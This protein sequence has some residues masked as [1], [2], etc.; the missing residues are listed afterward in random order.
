MKKF[1]SK[2]LIAILILGF[3]FAPVTPKID[4]QNHFSLVKNEARA[5]TKYYFEYRTAK[6]V[7]T[8]GTGALYTYTFHY[9]SGYD[10][11]PQCQAAYDKIS[12]DDPLKTGSK[13]CFPSETPPDNSTVTESG[14][15][16]KSISDGDFFK[17]NLIESPLQC[18]VSIL[19]Y[20][21]WTPIAWIARLS[22]NIL[23]FF[24]YYSLKSTSYSENTFVESGWAVVRD[25]ANIFFIV[26]LLYVAGKTV[27]GMNASDNKK[28][29][30]MVIIMAL[31]INF[32]LFISKV[33]IDASNILARVFYS[34]IENVNEN[35]QTNTTGD[36]GE[37]EITVGLVKVFDP[38]KLFQASNI[39]NINDHTGTFVILMIISGALMIYMII[40]FLSIAFLFVGRVVGLWI[41]MI[42]A[43]LAFASY[44]MPGFSIPKFNHRDWWSD[45]FKL[46]FMAPIFIFFL[47]LIVS[48]GDAFKIV[49]YGKDGTAFVDG[50]AA[51]GDVD[52]MKNYL[53]VIIPF[54]LIYVILKQAKETT[55]KMAGDIAQSVN[56]AGKL[57]TGAALG[58]GAA[59]TAM[60][61]RQTIGATAKYAVND[62]ARGKDKEIRARLRDQFNN[63][64]LLGKL[65]VFAYGKTIGKGLAAK[66]AEVITTKRNARLSDGS[67]AGDKYSNLATQQVVDNS[68]NNKT[69]RTAFGRMLAKSKNSAK[70]LSHA[71]H[72]L[73]HGADEVEKGA[74]YASLTEAQQDKVR[75]NV[76]RDELAKK[77]F[78]VKFADIKDDAEKVKL[79]DTVS[80][81]H[82][83]GEI[84]N[85]VHNYNGKNYSPEH[86]AKHM[87]GTLSNKQTETSAAVNE[88]VNALR[89]GSFDIRNLTD[90]KFNSGKGILGNGVFLAA[91]VAT[92]MRMGL[93]N[94]GDVNTGKPQKDFTKDLSNI[95]TGALKGMKIDIKSSGGGAGHDDGHGKKDDHGGGH[96]GGHH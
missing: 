59:G 45:L 91:A 6:H 71:K 32:S 95:I 19:Y 3:F 85:L 21:V 37:K 94:I 64:S 47:Y 13:T 61:A 88:F 20:L 39:N 1:F 25:I 70:D 44:T 52:T 79:K 53:S 69:G 31:L 11:L 40:T 76:N 60:I 73:D 2:I 46:S 89:K 50:T 58:L 36:E 17:C 24:I 4:T 26:A 34:S 43:P 29:I 42:F 12:L 16:L 22:A 74:T 63:S 41:L 54:A 65:N 30:S 83:N 84:G 23:D 18:F 10:D 86:D 82:K 80:Q 49:E 87:A 93:K 5:E 14:S 27:L 62:N 51:V 78:G 35:N 8:T 7:G 96:G 67:I 92:G 48:F 33:V 28:V 55:V 15:E 68:A 9:S 77:I 75:E 81:Y 56:T 38:Q 66:T 72:A 57:L 90:S